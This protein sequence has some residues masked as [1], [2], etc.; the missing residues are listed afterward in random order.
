MSQNIDSLNLCLSISPFIMAVLT[1]VEYRNSFISRPD[2][3]CDRKYLVAPTFE[4]SVQRF[5]KSFLWFFKLPY[6]M[7]HFPP[8][9]IKNR[10]FKNWIQFLLIFSVLLKIEHG[11]NIRRSHKRPKTCLNSTQRQIKIHE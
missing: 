9:Q 7:F 11:R 8:S 10:M 1:L 3:F 4:T 6:K 5:F 2:L